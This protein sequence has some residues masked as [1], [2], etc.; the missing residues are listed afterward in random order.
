MNFSMQEKE[1]VSFEVENLLK[2]GA[3]EQVCPQKDQFLSNV[4]IMKKKD[5]RQQT[6]DQ[7]E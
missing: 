1:T 7:L 6:C 5:E 2:K 3:V 4:F